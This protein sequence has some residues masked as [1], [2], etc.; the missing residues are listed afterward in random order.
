MPANYNFKNIEILANTILKARRGQQITN[1]KKRVIPATLT[2]KLDI[3]QQITTL[4]IEQCWQAITFKIQ[5]F[6]QTTTIKIGWFQQTT[7]L[8]IEWLQQTRTLKME[9]F[10]QTRTLKTEQCWRTTAPQQTCSST[11]TAVLVA[12]QLANSVNYGWRQL[13]HT[14]VEW[15][16]VA[17]IPECLEQNFF[18]CIVQNWDPP[19]H[20]ES[21]VSNV[22]M[23]TQVW[24]GIKAN[25]LKYNDGS[26]MAV[27]T[28][29]LKITI[30][31]ILVTHSSISLES[32]AWK[33]Y[34]RLSE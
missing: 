30:I 25:W 3:F 4:K 1:I 9:W 8:K 17:A 27:R 26:I 11:V 6:Q 24:N 15:V 21:R 23:S 31:A 2:V 7:T 34:V 12:W 19:D 16:R 18:L 22:Y 5:W 10:Q 29:K 33:W 13:S 32:S 14:L 28:K 20:K